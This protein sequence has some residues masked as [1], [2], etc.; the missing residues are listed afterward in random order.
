MV[1]ASFTVSRKGGKTN[2]PYNIN[3]DGFVYLQRSDRRQNLFCLCSEFLGGHE[4]EHFAIK[5][6]RARTSSAGATGGYARSRGWG[7]E[8]LS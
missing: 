1:V 7:V 4:N 3:L 6:I 8:I 2:V 5:R